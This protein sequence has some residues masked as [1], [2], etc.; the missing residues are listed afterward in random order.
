MKNESKI[1]AYLSGN[2]NDQDTVAMQEWIALSD[3]NKR[4]FE[5]T[6]KLFDL[7]ENER[8]F[9]PDLEAAWRKVAS[10]TVEQSN[11][12]IS[13]VYKMAAAIVLVAGIALLTNRYQ[14]PDLI[15]Y[16]TGENEIKEIKLRD[17]SVIWLNEN[18]IFE[19]PVSFEDDERTVRL[20]GQAFFDIERDVTRPFQI[21]GQQTNVMVLGTSFDLVSTP[22]YS[23]VNVVSGKV[24]M[25]LS[26]DA[27]KEVTLTKGKQA[28]FKNNVLKLESSFNENAS[29]WMTN[30]FVFKSTPLLEVVE[31][32]ASHFDQEIEVHHSIWFQKPFEGILKYADKIDA[33]LIVMGSKGHSEFEEILI[34]SNTEKVV[35]RSK[36]PVIVIKRD[37]KKFKL[38]NLV[39]A[40]SF[41]KDNKEVFK[42]FLDFANQ[43]NSKIHLLKVNTPSRFESTSDATEKIKE[44]IDDYKMPKHSI[45]IYNDTSIQGGIL[46]FSRD[47]NADLIALSTHGRSGLVHLFSASVTKRLSKKALKPMLTIKI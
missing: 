8:S 34:G 47:I 27:S 37:D 10:K 6:K 12:S 30:S 22:Q 19:Y 33:N 39:F 17:G 23:N 18:S 7:S 2:L 14:E 46:N 29:A 38:K 42:K 25:S 11:T 45:N 28:S 3:Q 31:A 20:K 9:T 4:D 24:S 35:R 1:L 43:F 5:A 26:D 32:L 16:S 13:W 40:S 44:F 36:R 21:L 15:S 41:K